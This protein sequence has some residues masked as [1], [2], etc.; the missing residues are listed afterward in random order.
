MLTIG[1]PVY[2][3]ADMIEKKIE[4]VLALNLDFNLIISDNHSTDGTFEKCIEYA[5]RENVMLI[6]QP[7]NIGAWNNFLFLL[8]CTSTDFFCITAQDDVLLAADVSGFESDVVTLC[9]KLEQFGPKRFRLDN[10][11]AKNHTEYFKN[12]R[13]NNCFYGIHRTGLLKKSIM[14]DNFL[15]NDTATMLNMLRYGRIKVVDNTTIKSYSGGISTRGMIAN[16]KST[17]EKI[18]YLKFTSWYL[19]E[20]TFSF[21]SHIVFFASLL[22]YGMGALIFDCSKK[23]CKY[24][25]SPNHKHRKGAINESTYTK[26]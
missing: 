12:A 24:E 17:G 25:K 26:V 1:L 4:S 13:H 3:C 2:N 16:L 9:G 20:Y 8:D 6:R 19:S 21:F 15:F 14:R 22:A 23:R 11:P 10:Y 5:T 7:K 18:P